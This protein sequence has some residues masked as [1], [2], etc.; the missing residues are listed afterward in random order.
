MQGEI[1][2]FAAR[3][4][5]LIAARDTE[6]ERLTAALEVCKDD[7]AMLTAENERLREKNDR[8]YS[9]LEQ[10]EESVQKTQDWATECAERRVRAEASWTEVA[11]ENAQL[12]DRLRQQSTK[13]EG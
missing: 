8:L 12:R 13:Q 6:I 10:V 3:A 11:L 7:T 5:Q 9:A 4:E 1:T 2:A